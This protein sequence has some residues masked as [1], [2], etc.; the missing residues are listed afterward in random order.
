MHPLFA[1]AEFFSRLEQSGFLPSASGV[2]PSPEQFVLL[3][4]RAHILNHRPISH[5]GVPLALMHEAFGEF[6]DIFNA[7]IP[8]H[9]D[10]NLAVDLCK[11]ASEVNS[12][13]FARL[14]VFVSLQM[15]FQ[16]SCHKAS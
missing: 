13:P 2:G 7:G 15:P 3:R 1:D 8:T 12:T 6:L 5:H 11:V 4:D 16:S 10:C 14:W 9:S